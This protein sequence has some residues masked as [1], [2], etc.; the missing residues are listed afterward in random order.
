MGGHL[1]LRQQ[2]PQI[3]VGELFDL[4]HLVRRPKAVEKVDERD[5]RFERRRVRDR[6]EVVRLLDRRGAEHREPGGPA[7]HDVRVIAEDGQGVGR[8]GA[9]RDVHRE[10]GQ[11]SGDFEQVGNHQEQPLR[12]REGRRERPGLQRAERQTPRTH[13]LPV[14]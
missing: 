2:G 6:R 13:K 14:A 10:R 7:G 11:L 8:D 4:G 1:R 3:V 9:R 12:R 5:P